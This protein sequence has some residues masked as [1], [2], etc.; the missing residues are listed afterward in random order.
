MARTTGMIV[1]GLTT[2]L[3]GCTNVAVKM[4]GS[5]RAGAEQL[6]MTGTF[7]RAIACLDF[8]PLAGQRVFLD[9]SQLNATDSGWIIFS[10]RR[11]MAK[12]GL[13]LESEKK[14]AQTIVEAAVGAYGT[15]EV[16]C[17][18][19]VPSLVAPTLLPSASSGLNTGALVRKNRQDAVVK[20]ALFAYNA[21]SRSLVWDSGT[22]LDFGHL[23]RHYLGTANVKRRSSLNELEHYPIHRVW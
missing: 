7:D 21:K 8:R 20:L 1:L 4:T 17:Q 5:S 6:L 2:A 13:L 15:D 3:S 23:D 18:I 22:I 12:Q 10:L 16:D 14:E 11:E 19:T 9:T